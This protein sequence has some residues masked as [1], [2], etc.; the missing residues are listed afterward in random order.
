MKKQKKTVKSQKYRKQFE[1][2]GVV[3]KC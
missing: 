3:L 2:Y 1:N